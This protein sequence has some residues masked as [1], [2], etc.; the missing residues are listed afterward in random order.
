MYATS[1]G[2]GGGVV[3]S[4]DAQRWASGAPESRS[5]AEAGRR[6]LHAVVRRGS[7]ARIHRVE[8]DHPSPV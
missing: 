1:P 4:N 6:R 3:L 2:V 5:V 7:C 8:R